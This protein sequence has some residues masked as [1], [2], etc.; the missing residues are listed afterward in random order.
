MAQFLRPAL[1]STFDPGEWTPSPLFSQIDESSPID[2]D[3]IDTS[4]FSAT[5]PFSCS[6]QL[7]SGSDPL[8][9]SGHIMRLRLNWDVAAFA[10][11]I[12]MLCNLYQGDVLNG[13]SYIAT[14]VVDTP[15]TI[16]Q[17]FPANSGGF[18]TYEYTLSGAEADSI[19]DYTDLWVELSCDIG[20]VATNVMQASWFEFET[21]GG[22]ICTWWKINGPGGDDGPF[23]NWFKEACSPA[24]DVPPDDVFFD[25]D[26]FWDGIFYPRGTIFTWT[27]TTAPDNTGWWSSDVDFQ[28]AATLLDNA[29]P[30]DLRSF[31]EIAAF[32]T[33]SAGV[34]GGFPGPAC[35]FGNRMVYAPGGYTVGT[36]LPTIRNFD[37]VSDREVAS[38][39]KTATGGIPKGVVTMLSANGTV[40]LTT[41]DSGTSASD[42]AGRVFELDMESG[43]LTQ[44]GS[45]FSSGQLPYCLAW[46]NG[47]LWMGTNSGAPGTTVGKIYYMRQDGVDTDWTIENTLTAA[48]AVC[49]LSYRGLLYIGCSASAGNSAK[50]LVRGVDN[51]YTTSRTGAGTA[52]NNAF[53]AMTLFG[54]SL[55][56]SYWNPSTISE[57]HQL[58]F[59]PG[60][61]DPEIASWTTVYDQT[62]DGITKPWVAFPV[63]DTVMLALAG[64]LTF[65]ASLILTEDG[66]VWED[67]T[68]FLT[69]STTSSTG[70]PGWAIVV[71]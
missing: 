53:L 38:L 16:N 62:D 36:D 40:Y 49:M 50:V 24:G 51:A 61:S 7:T 26:F 14:L 66:V 15:Y 69:Q 19:T 35:Q 32:A 4:S 28:G 30:K 18:V 47:R 48:C 8:S 27:S 46:H 9:S 31:D 11:S 17:S 6:M 42:F 58:S 10:T 52:A 20:D 68:V 43:N 60:D 65:T 33:G 25:F 55:Y 70:L 34:F 12:Q 2:A 39:P 67:R 64:G 54:D 44:I 3:F 5:G 59:V 23:G 1:D 22:D 13:G 57:I 56:T 41:L 63:D 71:R 37:G 21:P 29:R 45:A